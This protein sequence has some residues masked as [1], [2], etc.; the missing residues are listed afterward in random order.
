M[1]DLLRC[2]IQAIQVIKS[3]VVKNSRSA[4]KHND[5]SSVILS[6]CEFLL[7]LLLFLV[8]T[9]NN[10][11]H[12]YIFSTGFYCGEIERSRLFISENNMVKLHFYADSY[13]DRFQFTVYTRQVSRVKSGH[14]SV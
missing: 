6:K 12:H 8:Q 1:M 13:D 11:L 9:I 14:N 2:M 10:D 7:Q 4:K 5:D 3:N